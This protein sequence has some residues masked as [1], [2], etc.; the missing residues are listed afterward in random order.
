M[1]PA[2][3]Q[4]K[5][6]SVVLI[7]GAT[8]DGSAW[9]PVHDILKGKGFDVA[10]V[11]LP[12]TSLDADVAAARLIIGRQKGSVVLVAHSYGGVVASVAGTDPK[13]R[14]LVYVAA[15]QPDEGESLASL[16]ARAPSEN[17]MLD[18]GDGTVILDPAHY[19]TDMADDL[20]T[21]DAGFLAASQRPTAMAIFGTAVDEIA[22]RNKPS[23]GI[24]AARD[25]ILHPDLA[26]FMYA[27]SNATVVEIEASHVP[28]LSHP[29]A[30]AEVI[31]A[32]VD[33]S[34]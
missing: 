14:A 8:M 21:E 27:R 28:H 25:R 34:G 5:A 23:F 18:L 33:R 29:Q 13:V 26:R 30:V 11:Q 15:L 16:A 9:R 22:W 19:A 7:H 6:T 10:V 3:P 32:A 1:T 4:N 31:I 17:H 2:H 20:P 12:L 24:I